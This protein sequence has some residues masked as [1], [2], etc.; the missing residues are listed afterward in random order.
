MAAGTA[1]RREMML[2]E[3]IVKLEVGETVV[4][5]VWVVEMNPI[6][7]ECGKYRKWN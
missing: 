7:G 2:T 1:A 4:V 6:N 5:V 3:C